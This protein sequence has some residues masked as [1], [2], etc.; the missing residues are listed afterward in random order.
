LKIRE[1]GEGIKRG[2]DQVWKKTEEKYRGLGN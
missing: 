1:D 2:Q